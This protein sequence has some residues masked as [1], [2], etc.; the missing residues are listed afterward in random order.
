M[1]IDI[2]SITDGLKSFAQDGT[3]FIYFVSMVTGVVL[4]FYALLAI[5][6]KG[7]PSSSGSDKSWG[8]IGGRMMLA[9]C[10]ITL[11]QKLE[12]IVATNGSTEPLRNALAYATGTMTGGGGNSTLSLV[13][14]AISAWVVFL[15]TAG[16]MRGFLLFDKASQGGHDSGD[17][18]WRGLWHVIGGALCVNIFS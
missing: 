4:G 16:F 11:A 12:E 10:L 18:F 13:W 1:P 14:T 6:K 2:Q 5:A 8:A 9:S 15:G 17:S 3:G 7:H